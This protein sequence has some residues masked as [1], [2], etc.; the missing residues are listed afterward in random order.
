MSSRSILPWFLVSTM[1]L[2][3]TCDSAVIYV[4]P[5]E[6]LNISHPCPVACMS[7]YNAFQLSEYYLY[8]NNI[9]FK[10][11]PGRYFID[12]DVILWDLANISFI[13]DA[14]GV[15][16]IL[17]TERVSISFVNCLNIIVKNIVFEDCGY[18]LDTTSYMYNDIGENYWYKFPL[19][20]QAAL[21][22]IQ[23]FSTVLDNLAIIRSPGFG[24]LGINML[25][26]T[27]V[28]SVKIESS[29]NSRCIL[30]KSDID[31]PLTGG[32][33]L[34]FQNT[35]SSLSNNISVLTIS[36]SRFLSTCGI[37]DFNKHKTNEF[38]DITG[39]GIYAIF[40]QNSYSLNMV[41]QS[42]TFDSNIASYHPGLNFIYFTGV[43]GTTISINNCHF[44]NNYADSRG[45][46][47][48]GVVAIN[49]ATLIKSLYLIPGASFQQLPSILHKTNEVSIT[50]C[51]F[52]NNT[53]IESS[54]ISFLSA[55][56]DSTMNVYLR[57]INFTKNM[58]QTASALMFLQR[59]SSAFP[60]AFQVTIED[61][62]FFDNDL[63]IPDE[64][65]VNGQTSFFRYASVLVFHNIRNV[66]FIGYCSF[67]NNRGCNI[68]LHSSVISLNGTFEFIENYA[69]NGAGLAI[70]GNSYVL[71]YE[72]TNVS[73]INNVAIS[74]GGAIYVEE[75]YG[76]PS[77]LA[78]ICFLQYLSPQ[79]NLDKIGSIDVHMYFANNSAGENGNSI[80][81]SQIF[82]C[83]WVPNT[84]FQEVS[85]GNVID[86]TVTFANPDRPQISFDPNI[87]CFC[88]QNST[89][90]M[91]LDCENASY[92]NTIYPGE[93]IDITVIGVGDYHYPAQTII[94]TEVTKESNCSINGSKQIV[95]QIPN[96][97]TTLQYTVTSKISGNCTLDLWIND[98]DTSITRVYM[99][100][101]DCPF[102]F[103]PNES[104]ICDCHPLLISPDNPAMVTNC[105]LTSQTFRRQG[106]TWLHTV[107]SNG[108]LTEVI[109]R[110]FCDYCVTLEFD[111]SLTDLDSQ[112]LYKRSGTLCGQ[113]PSG[114]SSVFGSPQCKVC[115]NAWLSLLAA[116]AIAGIILVI[117]IFVLNLTITT[118]TINGIIFYANIISINE[119]TLFPMSNTFRPLLV[120]ISVLNLDLG[121]ETCFY[122]GMNDYVKIWLEYVFPV[123]LIVI[124]GVIIIMARYTSWAQ[125]VVQRNGVSVL[126]TLLFLSYTKLLRNSSMVL[127]YNVGITH[128][129]SG[130]IEQ[131]WRVDANVEYFGFKFTILF[132]VSL[133]I[134]LLIV[135]PL[136]L[137]M[138]FTKTFL[139]F[140]YVAHFKPMLDAYQSTFANPFRFWLGW[141][142]LTRA[143]VFSTSALD[144]QIVLLINSITMCGLAIMQAYFRP[145][146]SFYC[147]LWDLSFLL[148]L[149]T[150]FVVSLYFG[151]ANDI[152][153]TA[154]VGISVVQ[155]GAL[156][157]YHV[158]KA[159]G[160]YRKDRI[161]NSKVYNKMNILFQWIN[162]SLV[163]SDIYR[164]LTTPQEP[165]TRNPLQSR[166]FAEMR[167]P[168]V[169]PNDDYEDA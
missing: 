158:I 97:C 42:N 25:G 157:C 83:S 41:I 98:K 15:V 53:S 3:V 79:G 165:T 160:R 152:T 59:E 57:N 146:N 81:S 109:A 105:N 66:D 64:F 90:K 43:S 159:I 77:S 78:A 56:E 51:V 32:I 48:Q 76:I 30:G 119:T 52:A 155:F 6:P 136:T 63:V 126:S 31:I 75:V 5:D 40:G 151:N 148:N 22:F 84:A 120:F 49:Y 94:H 67:K 68:F 134:F 69:I 29:G 4:E 45:D 110:S 62:T 112:C 38:T 140:K 80:F 130:R 99:E 37:I 168:L 103:I 72:G 85:P 150:L 156:M 102:G 123:Y 1:I 61:C 147:N 113:C 13:G 117:I 162:A 19:V 143:L 12:Q 166:P 100:I 142:L 87:V 73:F 65:Y 47:L 104:G 124:V 74:R 95:N 82:R 23:C 133:L 18:T 132:V 169:N 46:S 91:K 34:L 107:N 39:S 89:Q 86:R 115:S 28:Q 116:F 118:G 11:Q 144:T 161:K 149:A 33:F 108:N 138:L 70:Y 139:R 24:V 27:R 36:N 164:H 10:L 129:P 35:P 58:G 20:P 21:I 55:G 111:L 101:P 54:G 7:L 167:E 60:T 44:T 71:L 145:F 121:V 125:R 153:V 106:H 2:L 9:I 127:F 96:T 128:L 135:I 163:N 88:V 17:C 137:V 122:D 50:N 92:G 131:V 8:N 154:L 114:Y 93:T 26:N 14:E 141:R 16:H